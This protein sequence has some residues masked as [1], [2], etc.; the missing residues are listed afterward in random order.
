MPCP[1]FSYWAELEG[2]DQDGE[3]VRSVQIKM[4]PLDLL[5]LVTLNLGQGLWM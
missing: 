1:A 5:I 4:P 3:V 2:E